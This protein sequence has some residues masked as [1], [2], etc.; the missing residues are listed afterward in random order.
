MFHLPEACGVG[1]GHFVVSCQFITGSSQAPQTDFLITLLFLFWGALRDLLG[2]GETAEDAAEPLLAADLLALL[3]TCLGPRLGGL[4]FFAVI[5]RF[6]WDEFV[7][8]LGLGRTVT[9]TMLLG[10]S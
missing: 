8:A 7:V 10:A 4:A 9:P 1:R 6:R 3:H 5:L 2:F